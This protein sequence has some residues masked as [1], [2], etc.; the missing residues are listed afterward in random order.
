MLVLVL[1]HQP[2]SPLPQLL[3]IPAWSCHGS[4]LSR[5]GAS[6][7]PGA[8]QLPPIPNSKAPAASST[9]GLLT[10]RGT[11]LRPLPSCQRPRA[12]PGALAYGQP[13]RRAG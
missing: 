3:G 2:H 13:G 6:K 1:D 4:N 12:Q 11:L 9:S 7:N 5:V 8:V 10:H